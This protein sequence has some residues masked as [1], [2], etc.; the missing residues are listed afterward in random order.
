ME[1]S[2]NS[3]K[4]TE[5]RLTLTIFGAAVILAYAVLGAMLMNNWAV[6]A[7]TGASLEETIA[8]MNAAD[9][10]Y[11]IVPGYLF[12][13]F[14]IVLALTWTALVRRPR[15]VLPD[16]GT[17]TIWAAILAFGAPAYFYGSFANNNNV[18]DTYYD[19]TR[20][21]AFALEA[22]LFLTSGAAL[23]LA[24]AVLATT[25]VRAA[26]DARRNGSP[27]QLESCASTYIDFGRRKRP[28]MRGFGRAG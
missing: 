26:K 25:A 21:A 27:L 14:G 5:M 24:V 10:P 18:G 3:G 4:K 7:A 11:R 6:A 19:W 2:N 9:Q 16:W 1:Q 17:L 23:I 28:Q 15:I 22:P 8:T 12:A 20:E 13:A